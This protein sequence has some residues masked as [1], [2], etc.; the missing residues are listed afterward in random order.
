MAVNYVKPQRIAI[1]NNKEL[2]EKWVQEI[3]ANDPA[4]IGLGDLILKDK[5]RIQPHA[6]RLDLLLQD[7]NAVKR[8][9]VEIQLGKT[10]ES[11]I[12]RTIEYWDIERK[13]FPQYEHCAVIIAEDITSRFFNVISL[14]NG[15]IPLIAIQMNAV[16]IG[17]N[18]SLIFTTVLD[19]LKLGL[20]D[21]DE[22]VTEVTDRTYWEQKGTKLTMGMA[23]E[24]L[25]FIKTFSPN[26]ELNYRKYYIGLMMDNQINN[27]VK[28]VPQKNNNLKIGLRIPKSEDIDE[29]IDV[30]GLDILE[31]DEK[32]NRYRIRIKK[33]ELEKK[34]DF[35]LELLKISYNYSMS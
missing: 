5:E 19:Q 14:F 2:D 32:W 9:E 10:D 35:L 20:V 26:F 24:L 4:I 28:M 3:I 13:R 15:F 16:K 6:G 22:D 34:K 30:S 29:K 7:E 17:D 8:F 33:D 1:K 31:Y 12:I 11:H 23:D 25:S 21:E 27:F 18:I